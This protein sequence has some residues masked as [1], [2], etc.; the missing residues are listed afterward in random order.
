MTQ[1]LKATGELG[2]GASATQL[3]V[4]R[5]FEGERRAEI[6]QFVATVVGPNKSAVSVHAEF[7]WDSSRTVTE[8]F[9]P[10]EGSSGIP[11]SQQQISETF[12]GPAAEAPGGVPGV[13]SNLP[14]EVE[15][16]GES[17]STGQSEY[18]RSESV[19][20]FD[21]SRSENTLTSAPGTLKRLAIEVFL[22]ESL[23]DEAIA[24]IEEGLRAFISTER[25]D[26]LSVQQIT[27]DTTLADE[28]QRQIEAA[29][30]AA[31]N[32]AACHDG[33]RDN[34]GAWRSVLPV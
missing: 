33:G 1:D 27:F 5:N 2:V 16:T 25:G 31:S 3:E 18:A 9:V 6:Q 23:G 8:T 19:T 34:R 24:S 29:E 7:K 12:T 13:S 11:R 17:A 20:N 10:T 30:S 15:A 14:G 32:H 28:V 21:I 4:Q 26:T 22:D